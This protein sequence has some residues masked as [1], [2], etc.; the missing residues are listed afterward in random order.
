MTAPWFLEFTDPA[1][2]W[3]Y[4]V[5]NGHALYATSDGGVSWYPLSLPE[6]Q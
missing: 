3:A 4:I 6:L 1:H 2:G 5:A